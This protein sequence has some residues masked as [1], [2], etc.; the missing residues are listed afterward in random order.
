MMKL[1]KEEITTTIQVV[2][3]GKID[4]IQQCLNKHNEKH[5][6]DM[7]RILPSLEYIENQ[8]QIVDDAKSSG[9]A[10]L[11]ISGF[12]TAIGSAFLILKTIFKF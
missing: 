9:K 12:I 1:M 6:Q 10:V 2:V 8:I 5:E 4:A 3:N 7:Q 11:W